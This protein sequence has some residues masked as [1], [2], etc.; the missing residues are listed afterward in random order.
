MASHIYMEMQTRSGLMVT[1]EVALRKLISSEQIDYCIKLRWAAM[2]HVQDLRLPTIWLLVH[3]L[4][5]GMA[6]LGVVKRV[7]IYLL[8]VL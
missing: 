8:G 6:R 1:S 3:S 7:L 4:Q 5:L 2:C